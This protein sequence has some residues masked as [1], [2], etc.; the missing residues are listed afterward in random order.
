MTYETITAETDAQGHKGVT[1]LTINR[2]QALNALNSKVLEELIGRLRR[3]SGGRDAAL[4]D[5]DRQR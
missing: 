4:C 1:L 3:L 2:P 5:P